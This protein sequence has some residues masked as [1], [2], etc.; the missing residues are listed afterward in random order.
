LQLPLQAASPETFGYTLVL[1]V[2]MF[3]AHS[4]QTTVL[5]F[6]QTKRKDV[7]IPVAG[8]HLAQTTVPAFSL[9]RTHTG[10]CV[11]GP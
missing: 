5:L 6:S 2:P 11:S 9:Y 10:F 1:I 4:A 7:I 3:G 8:V